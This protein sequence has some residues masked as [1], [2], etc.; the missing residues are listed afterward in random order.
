MFVSHNYIDMEFVDRQKEQERLRE[1]LTSET[2]RF[3]IVRGRRRIGKSALIG[4][5]LAPTDIYFEADMTAASNQM[6]LLSQVVGRHFPGFADATYSNWRALLKAINH[7]VTT[8]ITVCLDE[9]P[10]LVENTPALPSIIQGLLDDKDDPLRYHLILCGSS[11]QMMYN[12]THDESSPLY[13]R[14]DS[15]FNMRPI[16]APFLSEALG[17]DAQETIENYALWGGVP[18][19]WKLREAC[20]SLREAIDTHIFSN[21]G[22]LYEEPHHLFRDDTR[23]PVKVS[24][25]MSIVGSGCHR[26]SEIASRCNEPATNLSR[27]LAKLLDL[28]YLEKEIPFGESAKSSKKSLYQI[29]DPFLSF[30]YKFVPTNRSFIEMGRFLPLEEELSVKLPSHIGYWWE[31]LCRDA[32]S[33]NRVDGIVFGMASRWWGKVILEGEN[34]PRDVELDVVA[35]SMDGKSILIGECKWSAGENGRLLTRQLEK[36]AKSLPFTAGKNV[37]IK[38]FTKV[39]PEEDQGNALLPEDVLKML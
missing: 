36:M 21:M 24:T 20:T 9:F 16:S 11:Q 30:Y 26:V 38:L 23:D 3:I 19:Y 27:P 32:V 22:T 34:K 31:H 5:V 28:G 18:R 4:K 6:M 14:E 37:V 2:P 35:Q 17:L 39:K 7:R 12:L 29:A 1:L 15:D 8:P 10:Y 13:G 33:G 25:I